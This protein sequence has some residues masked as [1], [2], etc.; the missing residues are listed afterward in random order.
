MKFV[1]R[2]GASR[3]HFAN[4]NCRMLIARPS[5]AAVT[6]FVETT[7]TERPPR[8]SRRVPWG[9]AT[10]A[11][12]DQTSTFP[13]AEQHGFS[14][15]RLEAVME[16]QRSTFGVVLCTV[17]SV[18][19]VSQP[20]WA[21]DSLLNRHGL[22][23]AI[24]GTKLPGG[25]ASRLAALRT[26]KSGKLGEGLAKHKPTLVQQALALASTAH[27]NERDE[28]SDRVSSFRSRFTS[29]SVRDAIGT[30]GEAAGIREASEAW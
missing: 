18:A 20:A 12:S 11:G 15:L 14:S 17:L 4:A 7:A 2:R 26:A 23:S 6:G 21:A 8:L 19:A 3:R 27:D 5:P 1:P 9:T 30:L 28:V 22:S 29:K 10:G 25:K 24:A 16:M 13:Q